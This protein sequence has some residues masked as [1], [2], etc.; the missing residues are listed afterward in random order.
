MADSH[1]PNQEPGAFKCVPSAMCYTLSSSYAV[2]TVSLSSG[3]T[4]PA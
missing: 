2:N 3:V 1:D 4:K